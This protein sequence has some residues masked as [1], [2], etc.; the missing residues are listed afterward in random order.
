MRMRW[1]AIGWFAVVV[2]MIAGGTALATNRFTDVEESHVQYRDIQ[3]AVGQGW[4]QGYEDGILD[5]TG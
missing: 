3:F 5:P 4:F 1:R 2:V